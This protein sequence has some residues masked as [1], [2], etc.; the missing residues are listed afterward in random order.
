M[1]D[2]EAVPFGIDAS[3]PH[4]ARR[5]NYWLGGKDNFEADRRS[6]EMIA[7]AFPTIRM[8]AQENRKFLQ[9]AV[10]YLAAEQGV[11]QFLDIGTGLPSAGNV[12]EVAQAIDPRCRVVYVDND[13][14]VLAHARAL[15]ASSAEGAT[16][17]LE[18]D[19]REPEK[20]IGSAELR[21]TLDL[22]QPVALMLVAILHFIPDDQDPYGTVRR[23]IDVLPSGSYLV[24]SHATGDYATP[25]ER[26][27]N[28]D[29]NKRSGVPL[30]IRSREE[31][32]RFFDGLEMLEPGITSVVDWRSTEP[33]E[34]RPPV[35][36]ISIHGAVGRVP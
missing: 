12:H 5:Y 34:R 6:A 14:I 29:L 15:L 10:R 18:C 22:S 4:S 33:P 9:R 1:V 26:A 17:Y 11:T 35:R 23:L 32:A 19:L 13:P 20:I 7:S 21:E 3:K 16:A 27:A 30:R 8:A 36:D 28:P 24:M 2:D 31:F 25:E